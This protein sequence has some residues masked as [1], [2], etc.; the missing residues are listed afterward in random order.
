MIDRK[1]VCFYLY[2][3][4]LSL[5]LATPNKK[6]KSH[7]LKGS[8]NRNLKCFAFHL[9]IIS[10]GLKIANYVLVKGT[11][12]QERKRLWL[13]K[14]RRFFLV[15]GTSLK[16]KEL[17]KLQMIILLTRFNFSIKIKIKILI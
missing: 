9:F 11:T 7:N 4:S 14:K 3:T 5:A 10:C 13:S 8:P 1:K 2:Y 6:P 12:F 16:K 17:S 15:L